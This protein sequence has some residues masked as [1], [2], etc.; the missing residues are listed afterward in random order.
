MNNQPTTARIALKW[1]LILG[2]VSIIYSLILFLTDNIGNQSLGYLA[3]VFSIVAITLAMRDFKNLNGGYMSYGQGVG[4]GTLTAAISG[5]LSSLFSVFYMN[6]ID[7]GVMTRL[8]DKAREDMEARG[9]M[10]D[11]QID[12]GMEI[13]AKFQSPVILFIVGI[14]AAT[15]LGLV[16]SLV[17]SAIIRRDKPSPFDN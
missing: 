6:V 3:Y 4:L 16:F 9:N 14:I 12:Q 15:L 10:T 2:V 11:E 17:I 1:G 13:M 8:T 5:F 7:P